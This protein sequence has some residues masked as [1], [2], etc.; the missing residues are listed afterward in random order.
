MN[1]PYDEADR[2]I[3][4]ERRRQVLHADA[5]SYKSAKN[6]VGAIDKKASHSCS[7]VEIDALWAP[8]CIGR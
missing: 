8:I 1:V 4:F 3:L 7:P 5:C 2:Q 6:S